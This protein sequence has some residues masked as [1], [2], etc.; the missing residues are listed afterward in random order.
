MGLGGDLM[1]TAA[2]REIKKAYPD[3]N[4]YLVERYKFRDR[5]IQ[6]FKREKQTV[7]PIFQNNPYFSWGK[8][9]K[10]SIVI[11]RSDPKNSYAREEFPDR[12]IF[13]DEQHV[14]ELICRNYGVTPKSVKPDLFFFDGEEERIKKTLEPVKGPF[15]VIE[16]NGKTIFTENRLWF[17]DRWQ[18]L[19]DRIASYVTVVQ[20]GD[21]SGGSLKNV[22]DFNGWL[23]FRE[24]AL[25]IRKSSVFIGTIGGLMHAARAVGTMSIVLYSGYESVKLSGYEENINLIKQVDCSPCGLKVKCPY[26]RKCM[27][28]SV[29]DVYEIV[30]DQLNK[31]VA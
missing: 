8:T 20:I 15:V 11:D 19:V 10:G 21:G 25:I 28:F 23:S 17:W 18:R 13:K 24:A 22:V 5:I 9:G 30:M 27:N 26:Q 2:V 4:V 31:G 29:D 16:P 14:V 7:S 1:F 12:F 6:F 3:K